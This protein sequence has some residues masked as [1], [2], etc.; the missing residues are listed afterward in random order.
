[1]IKILF[2]DKSGTYIDLILMYNNNNKKKWTT[3]SKDNNHINT[4][5]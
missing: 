5:S 3:T 4:I 2:R 1:M